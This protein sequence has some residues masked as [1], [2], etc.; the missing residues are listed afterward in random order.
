MTFKTTYNK[1][2]AENPKLKLFSVY[3]DKNISY[4]YFSESIKDISTSTILFNCYNN[5]VG[6][7]IKNVVEKTKIINSIKEY[8]TKL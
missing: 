6:D 3:I 5:S 4:C 8:F 1:L 7:E 2:K